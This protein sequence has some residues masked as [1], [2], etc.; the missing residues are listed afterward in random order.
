MMKRWGFRERGLFL[1]RELLLGM[2]LMMMSDYYRG[3][4]LGGGVLIEKV[5]YFLLGK[6]AVYY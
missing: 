5:A 3:A 4:N 2:G 6:K 1:G